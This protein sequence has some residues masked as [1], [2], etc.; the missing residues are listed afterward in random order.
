M[1]TFRQVEVKQRGSVQVARIVP[2]QCK[3]PRVT[4]DLYH[5]F[6]MLASGPET[7]VLLDCSQVRYM[8]ARTLS[9]L[10]RLRATLQSRKGQLIVCCLQQP[11]KHVWE[12]TKLTD[13]LAVAD[14]LDAALAG[15]SEELHPEPGTAPQLCSTCPWPQEGQCG[16]C[17][18]RF[19]SSCGS[20]RLLACK[21]HR[22]KAYVRALLKLG[23]RLIPFP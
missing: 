2:E 14:S 12:I 18:A 20:L 21:Q 7:K 3:G 8:D 19:C 11:L 9:L 6:G 17:C 16:F 22:R 23:R 15:C 5:D 10:L 4:A 1:T 13:V